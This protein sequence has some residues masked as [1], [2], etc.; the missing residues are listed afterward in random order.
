MARERLGRIGVQ[1][2]TVRA[3]MAKDFEGTLAKVAGIGFQ[4]VEFAGYFGRSPAAVR[5]ALHRN[6]LTSP[7]AHLPFEGLAGDWE[8]LLEDCKTIG[9]DYALI[10]WTPQEAR[11][12]LDDWKRIAERFNRAGEAAR[13]MGLTF[14]YHNHDFEFKPLEGRV[15]FDLLLES[16]D[17]ELV[18]I[19]MDLY[20]ISY[21]GADPFAYF[22]RYPGR[23]PLVHVKDLK[24]GAEH[25]MVDVG[26][27]DIDWKGIFRKH[28]QA[29]IKHYFVEHDEPAD[30]FASIAASYGY[31]RGLEF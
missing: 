14:A 28:A 25:P 31:L 17:P 11:Q 12:S 18:R 16:T 15:P 5:E 30:A 26:A 27:G 22:T 2:Y 20:W 1:L 29:G 3:A 21:G 13:R 10:A 9:H 6:G 4:E 23:F 19:E 24:R 7:S 8:R